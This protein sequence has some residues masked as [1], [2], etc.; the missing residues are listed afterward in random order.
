M[1]AA[2]HG[3]RAPIPSAGDRPP[4]D[5]PTGSPTQ[6]NGGRHYRKKEGTGTA[7]PSDDTESRSP[8]TTNCLSRAVVAGRRAGRRAAGLAARLRAA[9]SAGLGARAAARLAR[10]TA[11]ARESGTDERDRDDREKTTH[12]D[13]SW[14]KTHPGKAGH[15]VHPPKT[16]HVTESAVPAHASTCAGGPAHRT[17]GTLRGRTPPRHPAFQLTS[18][19]ASQAPRAIRAAALY[20]TAGKSP[21][22]G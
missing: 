5:R 8:H 9:R 20:A 19:G 11:T 10:I 16:Q 17:G 14:L 12:Y 7:R 22:P 3:T 13:A 2:C 18:H 15:V 1:S 21:C 6:P 4:D